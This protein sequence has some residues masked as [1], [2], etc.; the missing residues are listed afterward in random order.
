M[1]LSLQLQPV[2]NTLANACHCRL[3]FASHYFVSNRA[4]KTQELKSIL[5]LKYSVSTLLLQLLQLLVLFP[6][7]QLA[8]GSLRIRKSISSFW[9][10]IAKQKIVTK[11]KSAEQKINIYLELRAIMGCWTDFLLWP[12]LNCLCWGT[13]SADIFPSL[14]LLWK[15][16][17]LPWFTV[18]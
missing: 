8:L 7:G 16:Q 11:R 3:P 1:L 17:L 12:S 5:E 13:I 2:K 4:Q 18:F 6:E 14:F 9:L 10:L 15:K